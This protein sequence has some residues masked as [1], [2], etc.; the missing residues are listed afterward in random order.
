VQ[1]R[2]ESDRWSHRVLVAGDPCWQSEELDEVTSTCQNLGISPQ[3]PA[4][5]VFTEISLIHTGNGPALLAVGRAGRS[6]FSASMAA[7]L[8]EPDTIAA[9]LACRLQEQPGW[10]GSTYQR[11]PAAGQTGACPAW[12]AIKPAA[13]AHLQVP[14]T[15]TWTYQLTAA[16][17]RAVPPASCEQL[18]FRSD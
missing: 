9:E 13:M 2:W 10:L 4:A 6:H 18:S 1:F 3:W 16:G 12:L 14:A 15:I 8:T 17:I 7:A 5:P 11:L